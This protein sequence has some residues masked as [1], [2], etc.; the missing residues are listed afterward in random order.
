MV[1]AE[2][3]PG[4]IPALVLLLSDQILK[5]TG[6]LWTIAYLLFIWSSSAISI[7]IPIV[8]LAS[9]LAWYF[10]V[11]GYV[12]EDPLERSILFTLALI[13]LPLVYY[14][15]KHGPN[16]WK[17]APVVQRKLFSILT[18]LIFTSIGVEYSFSRYW[19]EN[20]LGSERG[21]TYRGFTSAA[22]INELAFWSGSLAL[23]AFPCP[24]AFRTLGS[25]GFFGCYLLRDWYWPEMH[26]YVVKPLAILLL[27]I[28]IGSDF[29]YGVL[30]L[31]VDRTR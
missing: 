19:I 4:N 8:S 16:E 18:A 15:V 3:P 14:T 27:V 11:V 24:W 28:A 1:K 7:G 5:A 10:V 25:L 26:P 2:L 30:M 20:K 29:L 31:M 6:I 22:D 9:N 23:A 12:F 17:H 21:T 13:D